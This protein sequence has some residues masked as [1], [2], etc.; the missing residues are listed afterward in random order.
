MEGAQPISGRDFLITLLAGGDNDPQDL[1]PA[2]LQKTAFVV[3]Q[4]ALG[5]PENWPFEFLAHHYGPCSFEIYRELDRMVTDGLV[6][7]VPVQ[8]ATWSLYR[9]T[10]TG[11]ARASHSALATPLTTYIGVVRDWAQNQSFR[12]LVSSIYRRYPD[13]ARNTV[14]PELRGDA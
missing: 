5:P 8:G 14:A 2:R 4:E 6:E 13:W 9:L 1:D 12:G 3:C 11:L 10:Q 7:R